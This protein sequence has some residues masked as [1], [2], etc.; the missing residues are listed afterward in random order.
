MDIM[1]P[2]YFLLVA[3]LVSLVGCAGSAN[4]RVLVV[5][6]DHDKHLGCEALD[7]EIDVATR[8]ISEVEKDKN[9]LNEADDWDILLWFPLWPFAKTANYHMSEKTAEA[10]IGVL[11]AHKI[12]R[13]CYTA[14]IVSDAD[15][16]AASRLREVALRY[17]FR[18]T[19]F[20]H[21]KQVREEI[22]AP[23]KAAQTALSMQA[24]ERSKTMGVWAYEVEKL[25][26]DQGCSLDGGSDLLSVDGG[27][28]TYQVDCTNTAS[29][30]VQCDGYACRIAN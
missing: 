26:R 30:T 12:E 14:G 17:D 29:M 10:R 20:A 15:K 9:D 6:Q 16:K 5:S 19:T 21:Y 27:N 1:K 22:L 2:S 7:S 11:E 24:A 25:A 18:N 13:G 8:L 28:Q 3:S 4:H 23:R